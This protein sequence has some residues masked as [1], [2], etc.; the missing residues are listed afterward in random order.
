MRVAILGR[1]KIIYN[2]IR[3]IEKQGKHKIVLIG[4]CKASPEYTVTEKDFE[5]EAQRLGVPFFNNAKINSKEIQ[6]L[7]ADN[8]P[9]IGISMNWLN[10]IG[11]D[12]IGLFKNGIL[13]A[14]PG[15]LPKY[16]G[17][18]C[19]NWAIINGENR[20]GITIHY[21]IP[22]ELDSGNIVEKE[23]IKL[24]KESNI[25]EIYQKLEEIIPKLFIKALDM[26]ENGSIHEVS[27]SRKAEDIL[28][29]YPRK[30]EDSF[31]DW[32]NNITEIDRIV[33]GSGYPFHDAY[34]YYG[35]HKILV[36][37][38]YVQNYDTK[39][40]V[41][42]GQV[43]MVDKINNKIGIAAKDGVVVLTKTRIED[44]DIK[45][46]E[47]ITSVRCRL[48]YSINDKINEL[49]KRI[50]KLEEKINE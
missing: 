9:D 4:T 48:N 28:R 39:V 25:P 38:C 17:N 21:M 34:C 29:C 43:I 8:Q 10:V 40:L 15:D 6:K 33:R 7:I 50:I 5:C 22:G 27:Q 35:I 47:L 37:E 30:P 24:D 18:A 14:H 36:Q 2:T 31:I 12:T 26:I 13:N 16:R 32:N 19:P 45:I 3:E 44:E 11:E 20:I 42:P 23:Y 46:T 49:E 1:T 41:I